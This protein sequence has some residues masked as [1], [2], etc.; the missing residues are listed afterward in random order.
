[1]TV[2]E[3]AAALNQKPFRIIGDLIQSGIF[4]TLNQVLDSE[5]IMKVSQKYGF[6]AKRA[7]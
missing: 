4:A 5:T 7:V 1:M 2:A 3:L 6:I